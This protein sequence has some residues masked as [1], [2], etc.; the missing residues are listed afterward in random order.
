MFCSV[1]PVAAAVSDITLSIDLEAFIGTLI[2]C[3]YCA[4]EIALS[5][6]NGV[7]A[8]KSSSSLMYSFACNAFS[9]KY[10]IEISEA[11]RLFLKVRIA[12]D[13]PVIA[14]VTA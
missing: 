9:A 1:A 4:I 2:A 13:A 7:Y 12:S 14:P 8:A 6:L 3:K 5:V 11:S 10:V